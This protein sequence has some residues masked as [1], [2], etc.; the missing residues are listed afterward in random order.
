MDP[1]GFDRNSPGQLLK[2]NAEKEQPS[3]MTD[4]WYLS[5]TP[6]MRKMLSSR[7]YLIKKMIHCDFSCAKELKRSLCSLKFVQTL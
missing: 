1:I 4:I 2:V 7:F 6:L 5:T 3:I